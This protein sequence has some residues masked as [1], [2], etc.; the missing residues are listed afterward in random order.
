[1]TVINK[2][3]KE[4][5]TTID[6]D[7]TEEDI[8]EQETRGRPRELAKK[9]IP[10]IREDS[11]GPHADAL[12]P[13]RRQKERDIS[14]TRYARY[15]GEVVQ[16]EPQIGPPLKEN[17]MPNKTRERIDKPSQY[18]RFFGQTA[19]GK[20]QVGPPLQENEMP[21]KTRNRVDKPSQYAR[22]LEP[23][24][25]GDQAEADRPTTPAPK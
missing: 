17:E 2:D 22:S 16:D 7:L 24:G 13:V 12:G 10:Q 25:K 4:S 1:M 21:E 19:P 15:L 3:I 5:K 6:K 14:P 9:P 20:P 11:P 23:E 8:E 18:A